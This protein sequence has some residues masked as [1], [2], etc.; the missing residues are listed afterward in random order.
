M[1]PLFT[2]NERRITST[3]LMAI[4]I[5]VPFLVAAILRCWQLGAHGFDNLYYS[6]AV[7]SMASDWRMF[8]FA[9]FDP[10]GFLA[11]GKP[12]LAFWIQALF[13]RAL[14]FSSFSIHIPQALAG[15]LSVLLIFLLA[16][17]VTRTPGA[18]VAAMVAAVTPASVAVDRSNLADSWLLLILLGATLLI[19]S[20]SD[21]GSLRKLLLGSALL[22][23]GFLTKFM[24]AYVALPALFGVYVFTTRI[25]LRRR[26]AHLS[27]A[28]L[29]LAVF[30]FAWP[31]IV[32]LTPASERPHIAETDDSSML[33]LALGSQGLSRILQGA[34]PDDTKLKEQDVAGPQI[35][36]TGF[37]AVNP[38]AK[39][40]VQS[41]R[42]ARPLIGTAEPATV[43]GHGGQPGP[44][45]LLNRDMAGHISWF[46][47]I[48]L[49]G[50]IGG[51]HQ[52]CRN[53]TPWKPHRD[54]LCWSV[55]FLSYAA[56]FSLPK[57]FIHSYY[58]TL[59]APPVAIFAALV[60]QAMVN[61]LR[62]GRHAAMMLAVAIALTLLWHLYI[63]S[64]YPPWARWLA[65]ALLLVGLG[66]IGILL[67]ARTAL[68]RTLA[69]I[70]AGAAVSLCPLLWAATPALG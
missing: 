29:V 18:V 3:P 20:A 16:R 49:V 1:N 23:L 31:A 17:R 7:Y 63:I 6:P 42:P 12:P 56:V 43:T 58:L 66:A 25:S 2:H 40:G 19:L 5:A 37:S 51:I 33:G 55:W 70:C 27:L 57:T 36:N 53:G 38:G 44:L 21:T 11:I 54:M 39:P 64:S 52:I 4:I 67:A 8:S 14:G 69:L 59:L 47:P 62:Q 10:A 61:A 22:G 41:G 65:P 30:S 68:L 15:I 26:L 28:G 35:I 60:M 24:A 50:M 9:S 32:D 45:R 48:L 46:F 13:A 34:L